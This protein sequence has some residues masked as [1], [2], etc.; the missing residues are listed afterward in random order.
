MKFL[1]IEKVLKKAGGAAKL[2]ETLVRAGQPYPSHPR[3]CNWVRRNSIPAAWTGAIIWA[4]ACKGV[5]PLHLLDDT[6]RR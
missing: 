3:M 5:N 6:A 4:L 1:S 2:Q